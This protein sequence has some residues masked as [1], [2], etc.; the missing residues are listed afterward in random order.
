MKAANREAIEKGQ[1]VHLVAVSSR[2]PRPQAQGTS[3]YVAHLFPILMTTLAMTSSS[4]PN[5]G[6]SLKDSDAI[7]YAPSSCVALSDSLRHS[8]LSHL[9]YV[10]RASWSALAANKL[11]SRDHSDAYSASYTIT[12]SLCPGKQ[13]TA[14]RARRYIFLRGL[15]YL[16][17]ESA[18]VRYRLCLECCSCS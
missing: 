10:G 1:L 7:R 8:Q 6:N 12:D 13:R 3:A 5:I 16:E 4:L 14:Q 2:L 11:V 18:H 9:R 15:R 17:A